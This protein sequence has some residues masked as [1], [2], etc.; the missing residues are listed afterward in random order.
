LGSMSTVPQAPKLKR[1]TLA[2][3][4]F[5]LVLV[6]ALVVSPVARASVVTFLR[7]IGGILFNETWEYPGG[8]EE[9]TLAPEQTL[10]LEAARAILPF[11]FGL[12]TWMPEGY[13][14]EPMVRIVHFNEGFTPVS[15][16]F[17][18]PIAEG[19]DDAIELVVGQNTP[20]WVIGPESAEIVSIH[21][22]EAALI[23]GSWN[24]QT[25]RWEVELGGL[26]LSWAR[27]E[28]LYQLSTAANVHKDDLIRI[29]ESI[30]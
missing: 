21:G 1:V 12:P 11:T 15:I 6:M 28:V 4:G 14:M 29:A 26:T 17:K 8:T 9:E 23:Q 27:E 13:V 20:S 3:A 22:Q 25:R 24:S 19:R 2:L 10:G 5:S 30:P 7:E 16:S 18:K